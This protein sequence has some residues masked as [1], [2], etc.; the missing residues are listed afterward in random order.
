MVYEIIHSNLPPAEK[1]FD[2]ILEELATVTGAAFETT[3]NILRLVLYHVFTN[4]EVL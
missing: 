4:D 1:T 3:A 2:R